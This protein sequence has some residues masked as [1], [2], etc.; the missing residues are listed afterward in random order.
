MNF[1]DSRI[2]LPRRVEI[3]ECNGLHPLDSHRNTEMAAV[4]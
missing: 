1:G 4:A 3:V 2:Q